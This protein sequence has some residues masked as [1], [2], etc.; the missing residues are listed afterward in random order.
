MINKSIENKRIIKNTIYLNIRLFLAMFIGL[1]TSREILTV[2]GINDFGIYSLVG[3]FV[4]MLSIL[5]AVFSGTASRFITYEIGIG[6]FSRLSKTVSTIINLLIFISI[7]VFILGSFIGSFFIENY[8]NIPSDRINATYF[9][10]YCSLFVFSINLLSV[11]YQAI[12][13]AHEHMSFYG[14]MGIFDSII[15]LIIVLVLPYLP[16]DKLYSYSLLLALSSVICRIIYGIYCNYYFKESKY[17]FILDRKVAKSMSSFSLWMGIGS[18]S[19]ILKDQGLGI[20]INIFYG[21]ALNAARGIS[22]QVMNIF[23]NFA[24]NIGL[25]ISP[26][27]T[28]SYSQE[29]YNR[30]IMLTF[31]SAKAQGL[32]LIALMVPFILE[33]HYILTLWLKDV[34]AYTTEFVCWGIIIV[35]AH[36]LTNSLSPIYLAIGN[37]RNIQIIGSF[38]NFLYII[39]CYLCCKMGFNVII[40]LQLS[41]ILEIILFLI[42]YIHIKKEIN[43]PGIIFIKKAIAPVILIGII[44]TITVYFIQFIIQEDSFIRVLLSSIVSLCTVL[45]S[46]YLFASNKNEKQYIQNF[47]KRKINFNNN[48]KE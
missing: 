28:K 9:V 38:I 34:P 40:C 3:G 36:S 44:T 26:Q 4:S 8:L 39:I 14:I 27:I 10:Y 23:N 5:T 19:G 20:L 18:A 25:A 42:N 37:I 13:T 24:I 33:S 30:S 7:G 47:I 16:F 2:L 35:F 22:L 12:I 6:D 21:L 43:F 11:P 29:N 17:R 48:Q 1:Y 45:S 15:K 32:I 46:F 31:T 41:V